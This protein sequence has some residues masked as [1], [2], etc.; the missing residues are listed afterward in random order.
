[1]EKISTPLSENHHTSGI[2]FREI[3]SS[4]DVIK[5]FHSESP[6]GQSVRRVALVNDFH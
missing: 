3:L 1:M 2:D 6:S 4:V 5:A